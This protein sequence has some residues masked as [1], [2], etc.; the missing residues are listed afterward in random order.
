MTSCPAGLLFVCSL[1]SL[2]QQALAVY[3]CPYLNLVNPILH[4]KLH[5]YITHQAPYHY[6]GY[7][8]SLALLVAGHASAASTTGR[9]S[10][11]AAHWSPDLA[12]PQVGE[13]A[14]L[15][16]GHRLGGSPP[17]V[18][19]RHPGRLLRRVTCLTFRQGVRPVSPCRLLR[20]RLCS[21]HMGSFR[22]CLYLR[23]RR[24]RLSPLM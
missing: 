9:T 13:A 18:L 15:S 20:L 2:S 22:H 11:I 24:R 3:Q 17:L 6:G 16:S 14:T 12:L 19:R 23:V 7:S 8:Q 21:P 4:P 1:E 10:A 5:R